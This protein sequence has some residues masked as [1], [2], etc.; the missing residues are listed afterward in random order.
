VNVG[1]KVVDGARTLHFGVQVI[2]RALGKKAATTV[3]SNAVNAAVVSAGTGSTATTT[4]AT[5]AA[6]NSWNP[7]GF[8][9]GTILVGAGQC[10]PGTVTWS[11]YKPIIGEVDYEA[12]LVEPITLAAL[13]AHPKVQQVS[14]GT[15][16]ASAGLPEVEVDNTARERYLLRGV[17]LPW[18]GAAYHAERVN[19]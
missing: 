14:V 9:L 19:N 18:G 4:A 12:M 7:V 2:A 5:V 17:A 3:V 11:C 1:K 6:V 8:I 13:V 15:R 10:A 16:A